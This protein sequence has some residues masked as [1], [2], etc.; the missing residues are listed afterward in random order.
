MWL[1]MALE[2]WD[3]AL[4]I[5]QDLQ[6]GDNAAAL[7]SLAKI[8]IHVLPGVKLAKAVGKFPGNRQCT[9]RSLPA[10]W[11]GRGKIVLAEEI[12]SRQAG[13]AL[14]KGL[15]N[16]GDFKCTP[17]AVDGA[18]AYPFAAPMV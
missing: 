18:K 16:L 12:L 7:E 9:A 17:K 3:G 5:F 10:G 8:G 1:V 6:D 4:E 14:G 13:K 2:V 15:E 11:H